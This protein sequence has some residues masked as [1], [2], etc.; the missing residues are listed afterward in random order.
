ML[1]RM[2]ASLLATVALSMAQTAAPTYDAARGAAIRTCDAID[3]GEY[4]TGLA[5]NP[6]GYR[7]FYV[8]SEC[9]QKAAV[10]FRDLAVCDRVRQRRALF[11]SSWGYSPA[12]CRTLVGRAVETDRA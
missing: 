4:Q 12:N 6:D 3:A 7:S 2:V 11:S 10:H 9:L 5:F 1:P 8:R